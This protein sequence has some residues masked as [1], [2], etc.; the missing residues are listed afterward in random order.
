MIR[1]SAALWLPPRHA[2]K[3]LTT[4]SSIISLC[5]LLVLMGLKPG[6]ISRRAFVIA[7]TLIWLAGRLGNAFWTWLDA[8]EHTPL[9]AGI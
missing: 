9:V 4:S 8:H 1:G 3:I 7:L 2:Q 5:P 6:S